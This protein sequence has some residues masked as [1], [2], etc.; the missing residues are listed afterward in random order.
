MASNWTAVA[1]LHLALTVNSVGKGNT[2][3]KGDWT[4]IQETMA[5]LG[6]TFTEGALSQ[7]WS[8]SIMKDYKSRVAAGAASAGLAGGGSSA[9]APTPT[10]RKRPAPGSSG[11][12]TSTAAPRAQ[13]HVQAAHEMAANAID[14]GK[15]DEEPGLD[16]KPAAKRTKVAK[17]GLVAGLHGQQIDLTMCDADDFQIEFTEATTKPK[18][19]VKQEDGDK[20]FG[21]GM[22]GRSV[23]LAPD[24]YF[25]APSGSL[26]PS[27]ERNLGDSI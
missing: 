12:K 2:I 19:E 10:G 11:K 27:Q 13:G 18:T 16:E 20:L 22:R 17:R 9:P 8:K 3:S 23:T 24:S 6:Y 26:A 1:E 4:K 25:H 5:S 15:D 7:R 14:D 21:F